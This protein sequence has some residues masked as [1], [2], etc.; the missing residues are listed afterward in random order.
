LRQIEN[1]CRVACEPIRVTIYHDDTG[2]TP[3]KSDLL[4]EELPVLVRRLQGT[5]GAI[6]KS[7]DYDSGSHIR[8]SH[9][10]IRGG[11]KLNISDWLIVLQDDSLSP[12][13]HLVDGHTLGITLRQST[14]AGILHHGGH[15]LSIIA[16]AGS[17]P[18][19]SEGQGGPD[20]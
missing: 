2:S 16:E 8:N 9:Q 7:P 4:D 15:E 10:S 1:G 3:A 18:P 11:R 12:V 19:V 17:S 14:I 5:L 6:R 13:T 20:E